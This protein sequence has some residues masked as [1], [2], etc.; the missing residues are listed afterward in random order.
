MFMMI[1]KY[2]SSDSNKLTVQKKSFVDLSQK[3][4]TF[5]SHEAIKPQ[6]RLM[7][8]SLAVTIMDSRLL[9]SEDFSSS[10]STFALICIKRWAVT[11]CLE[12]I[13]PCY[14]KF[15]AHNDWFKSSSDTNN[16]PVEKKVSCTI[17]LCQRAC[18]FHSHEIF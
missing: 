12:F 5:H 17:N 11:F 8:L 14:C 15:D 16:L 3:T 4:Y 18:I 1:V 10:H 13:P 7:V 6:Q 9:Q 2:A